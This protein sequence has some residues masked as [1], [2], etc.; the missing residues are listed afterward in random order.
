VLFR[1]LAAAG[2]S[3]PLAAL[4]L[5]V[6]GRSRE[7]R[8]SGMFRRMMFDVTLIGIVAR[9]R[10]QPTPNASNTH[11][12]GSRLTWYGASELLVTGWPREYRIDTRNMSRMTNHTTAR[13]NN[14][15]QPSR[16]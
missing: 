12:L 8:L 9:R 10:P 1:R 13:K 15:S 7:Q 16:R 11:V 4:T 5:I 2:D 6:E 3:A 14:V